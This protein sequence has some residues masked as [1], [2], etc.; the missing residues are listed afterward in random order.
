MGMQKHPCI[1]CGA[2]IPESRVK[3]NLLRS[4]EA[5]YCSAICISRKQTADGERDRRQS[6]RDALHS[7]RRK[8]AQ[9]ECQIASLC[10]K[11]QI[12]ERAVEETQMRLS[13]SGRR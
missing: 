2:Q 5:R 6:A 1:V 3:W 7:M 11:K 12:M 9:L 10:S 8:I 13:Q 4:K